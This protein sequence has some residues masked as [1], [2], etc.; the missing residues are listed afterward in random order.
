[1]VKLTSR[2]RIMRIFK[3]QEIDRPSLKLWG[4]TM[5]LQMMHPD[6]Q[7][8]QD[9]AMELTDI[10][11]G[12]GCSIEP[13]CGANR[14]LWET[15]IFDT[16][17]PLWKDHRTTLHTPMG[18]LY[19]IARISTIGEPGYTIRYMV[20]DEE[21]LEKLLSVPYEPTHFTAFDAFEVRK[22]QLGERGV[23]MLGLPHA[24]YALQMRTG[25][26]NLAYFSVDCREMVDEAISRYA[27]RILDYVKEILAAGV[28]GPFSWVGPE[29]LIPP[30]LTPDDFMDFCYKYDKPIC[31]AI[32]DAGGYVWVHCHGKVAKLLDA[33][34]DMG[35][36][37]L[38]P[39][40]PPK[41]GDVDLASDV[42]K[43]GNRIGWEGNIEIQEI[44]LAP[45]ERLRQLIYECVQAGAPSGRFI[46]CPSAGY[47]EYPRPT[48]H[49]IENL[50]EYMRYGHACV[51][52][53]RK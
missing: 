18:D 17:N 7:Q 33:F 8:I 49:Y 38:N 12:F 51:E 20:Q 24:G 34:I 39:L 22:A 32:H 4:A 13:I 27:Q 45:K 16:D 40:E 52:A 6:Y 5:G 47:M 50:K 31:D 30:L 46:L 44:L 19:Q 42:R 9:M 37:I 36:D 21:D 26:E 15:E 2:E 35:V 43:F 11:D 14:H 41:N 25:S 28:T 29:L 10:Y 1:M 48:A 23:V 53:C 3:N